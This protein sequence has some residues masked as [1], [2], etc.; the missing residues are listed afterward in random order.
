MA[1]PPDE[2]AVTNISSPLLAPGQ[3]LTGPPFEKHVTLVLPADL[4]VE[5]FNIEIHP[6]VK[7]AG[8]PP[9]H[10]IQQDAPMVV[11]CTD[12]ELEEIDMDL[13][14]GDEPAGAHIGKVVTYTELECHVA[15][16]TSTGEQ[17]GQH[18]TGGGDRPARYRRRICGTT[19]RLLSSQVGRKLFAK[20]GS[21]R[22]IYPHTFGRRQ[23]L[24]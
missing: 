1:D 17:G 8:N 9:G 5:E 10:D 12:F 22:T 4:E 2:T 3:F 24:D 18:G 11:A 6:E 7:S 23:S 19:P 21:R 15:A 16:P 13:P 20:H 14:L